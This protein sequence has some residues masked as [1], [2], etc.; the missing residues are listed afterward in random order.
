MFKVNLHAKANLRLLFFC[1][2]QDIAKSYENERKEEELGKRKQGRQAKLRAKT[3]AREADKR[4][5]PRKRKLLATRR[6]TKDAGELGLRQ[7]A[8]DRVN[9]DLLRAGK[10]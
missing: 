10:T 3:Q 7:A 1:Y 8:L 2:I 9:Q 4:K 6:S 5:R